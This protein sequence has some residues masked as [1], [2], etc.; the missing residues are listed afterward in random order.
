M[1][2]S[3]V[4]MMVIVKNIFFWGGMTYDFIDCFERFGGLFCFHLQDRRRRAQSKY[5]I[6]S[7]LIAPLS[8]GQLSKR[9]DHFVKDFSKRNSTDLPF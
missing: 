5:S 1:L 2:R 7:S 9:N 4:Q 6:I 8:E 3:A